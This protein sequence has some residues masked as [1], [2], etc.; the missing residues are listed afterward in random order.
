[1]NH[2]KFDS[3]KLKTDNFDNLK[4]KSEQHFLKKEELMK[5]E[6]DTKIE[7]AIIDPAHSDL[8]IVNIS[9]ECLSVPLCHPRKHLRDIE[10]LERSIRRDGLQEPLLVYE[11][12]DNQYRVIDGCRRLTVAAGFGWKFVPCIIKKDINDHEA[13]HLSYVKNNERHGFDP[14]EIALHLKTMHEDFKYSLRDLEL[15]GYGSPPSISGKIK[16]LDLPELVQ[17]KIQESELTSAHGLHLLKLEKKDEQER[18]AKQIIDFGLTAKRTEIRIDKYLKKGKTKDNKVKPPVSS[19]DIPGVY[20]KDS[21][22]MSELPDKSVHMILSSP[23]Y[24]VGMEFEKGVPFDEHVETVKDVLKECARVLVP[25]GIMALNVDDIKY[26]KGRKGNNDFVQ[27]QLMAHIFQSYLRKYKIFLTDVIIWKKSTAWPK[28]QHL[29]YSEK[30]VHTKY[31]IFDNFE[32][33]YIF[34]KKGERELPSEEVIL[35]SKLNKEEYIS[36]IPG[37]WEIK[38]V[39]NMEE[40]PC[41]WPDELPHRLV[42]MFTY[43]GDN[44]LDPWLGSGTTIKVARELNREGIGY[45]RESQYKA[46]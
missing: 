31:G 21:R 33:V 3:K 17:K 39:Q 6:K 44:V 22:D 7:E 11:S 2:E 29:A 46:V 4:T 45:E 8:S 36:W 40:H 1:M 15:K 34:R 35:K 24:N 9:V 5:N 32:P 25:G 37:V 38:S 42:K 30:L 19:T 27:V 10:G 14:I 26:F 28:R 13:A 16:L 18:M 41:I 23:P 12:G 20:I 43:E